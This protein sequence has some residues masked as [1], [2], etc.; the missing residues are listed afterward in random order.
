M[1]KIDIQ[2][3]DQAIFDRLKSTG[4]ITSGLRRAIS[5]QHNWCSC[6]DKLIFPFRPAFA[7][8]DDSDRPMLGCAKCATSRLAELATPVYPYNNLNVSVE[9]GVTLWRYMDF[10]KFVAMLMQRGLYFPR[11]DQMDDK[12]EGALGLARREDDWDSYYLNHY[13]AL[14]AGPG[15]DGTPISVSPERIESEA[16]RLLRETKMASATARSR[17]VSCWHANHGESEAQWRLYCP[18][19]TAGV[20][21]RSTVGRLWDALVDEPAAIVGKVHYLDFKTAYATTGRERIF[22]KRSSLAHERE[23][24]AVILDTVGSDTDGRLVSCDLEGLIE[25]V[26]VSPTAPTWFEAVLTDIIQRHGLTLP[27]HT[28]ELSEPPF[29]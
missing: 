21:L 20:A 1:S 24:R 17:P 19:G 18:P 5:Q 23:V 11:A 29:Y 25:A 6:C 2:P 3:E 15:P 14:I 22:C 8:Y 28:S 7:G 12:F 26:I 9:D 13:R 4:R 16:Q 10:S 27:V